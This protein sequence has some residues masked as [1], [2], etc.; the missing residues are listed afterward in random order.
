MEPVPDCAVVVGGELE[1][2][3]E[4]E[5][6]TGAASDIV[7]VKDWVQPSCSVGIIKQSHIRRMESASSVGWPSSRRDQQFKFAYEFGDEK[8]TFLSQLGELYKTYTL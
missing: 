7:K 3:L 2:S 1:Q 4:E 6:R 8:S 5:G